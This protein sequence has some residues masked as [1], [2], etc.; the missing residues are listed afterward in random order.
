MGAIIGAFAM[1]HVVFEP[2]KS[3]DK[4]RRVWAGMREIAR[5]VQG[6]KPDLLIIATNDHLNNFTLALQAPFVVVVAD[7]YTPLGDMGI[8]KK[9]CRGNREFADG[10]VRFAAGAGFDLARAEE[11][12]PDHGFAFPNLVVNPGGRIPVLPFYINVANDIP[13]TPAR[14]W[15]LG[16]VVRDF[17]ARER[18]AAERVVVLGAGGLSHWLCEPEQGRVNEAFDRMVIDKLVSGRAREL[19]ALTSAQICLDAGRS[20]LEVMHWIFA[21]ATVPGTVAEEVFYEPMPE[22]ITGLGGVALTP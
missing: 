17:V 21:A 8:P 11:V 19:A 18:P 7:E 22:W 16:G 15:S 13:P 6:L 12:A 10:L 2:E 3:P 9:P 4:A 5:R 14:V 1:S 20:G